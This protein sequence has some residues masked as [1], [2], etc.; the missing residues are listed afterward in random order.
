MMRSGFRSGAAMVAATAMLLGGATLAAANTTGDRVGGADRFVTAVEVSKAAFP[1]GLPSSNLFRLVVLAT[2]ED[3]PDAM[4]AGAA[5]GVDGPVLLT[6]S[7][8][9]PDVVMEELER[10]K[11][12]GVVI[13]GGESAVGSGIEEKLKDAGLVVR[14]LDGPNR[15]ATAVA[16]SD[17]FEEPEV[18]LLASGWSFPDA[19]AGGVTAAL[20]GAPILLT[21]PRQLS[22][23]TAAQLKVLDPAEIVILG[24]TVAVSAKVATAAEKIAPVSRIAGEDRFATSA[25]ISWETFEEADT[26]LV[27]SGLSYPDALAGTPLAALRESPI[28]LVSPDRV[29]PSVC[30]EIGRLAP[31]KVIALGGELAISKATLDAAIECAAPAP[32]APSPGSTPTVGPTESPFGTDR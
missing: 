2:G 25:E 12:A 10:L 31:D 11:P 1:A 21:D 8:S 14:R 13:V 20:V 5:A 23:E 29:A 7:D 22:P 19:L 18:V 4:V 28:L 32:T 17:V 3:Y 15:Y 30:E 26:V 27:A 9:I 6:A 24:G 16:V